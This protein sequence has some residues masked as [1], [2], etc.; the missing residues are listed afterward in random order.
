MGPTF[1]LYRR[2]RIQK[3]IFLIFSLVSVSL[4]EPGSGSANFDPALTITWGPNRPHSPGGGATPELSTASAESMIRFANSLAPC[5]IQQSVDCVSSLEVA[6]SDANWTAAT[7]LEPAFNPGGPAVLMEDRDWTPNQ[8]LNIGPPT[9]CNLY[10]VTLP[11]GQDLL[12]FVRIW[13]YLYSQKS[14]LGIKDRTYLAEIT[15]VARTTM[16]Q[17]LKKVNFG[18]DTYFDATFNPSSSAEFCYSRVNTP[19]KFRIALDTRRP[20]VGWIETRIG[21]A[22]YYS[23]PNSNP[24]LPFRFVLEGQSVRV[25]VVQLQ[26]LSSDSADRTTYCTSD[27]GLAMKFCDKT[28]T[29]W[30]G[31]VLSQPSVNGIDAVAVYSKALNLFPRLDNAVHDYVA[32]TAVLRQSDSRSLGGCSSQQPIYGIVGGNAMLISS[33]LPVWNAASQTI[34]FRVISPHS[35]PDGSVA[36]GTYEMQIEKSVA[37]CLWNSEVLPQNVSFSVV[38]DDGNSKV[39]TTTVSIANGMVALRAK[40]FNYSAA[41]LRA[42]LKSPVSPSQGISP[43]RRIRCTNG[44]QTRLQPLGKTTCPAGW[45]KKR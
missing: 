38:S 19:L 16:A 44:R 8:D 43:P 31:L 45:R 36:Q 39:A 21:E 4:I 6:G 14:A 27:I 10:K 24:N 41:T 13:F 32:W 37:Q 15:P 26:I 28:N 40:G 17:C 9:C 5:D 25:P 34:E 42:A 2:R 20:I 23:S 3:T 1:V 22:N 18:V 7:Y 12:L 30:W 33:E 35:N 29:W 11:D